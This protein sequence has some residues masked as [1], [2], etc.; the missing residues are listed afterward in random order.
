[1]TRLIRRW[2]ASA[3]LSVSIVAAAVS[4]S[5]GLD[6]VVRIGFQK[7]GKLVLLKGKGSLEQKLAPLGYK[8]V[9][10]EFPSGPPLLEAL[11]VGA[12]D[13]GNTGEA[14]PIFAQA[15]GAPIQY[16][17]YEPPAPK[18]EA[19]L[20]QKDSK[21]NSIADLKGRKVALNKGSN[22]HYLLVKALE[23]A[24]VKY[25]EIEPVFLAPADARAAFER[26]S[27]DAWVIWDPFQA[28][29][30]AA[31]GARTL[32]DGT[33]IVSNYQ[34]YFSSKKFL[35]SDPKIVDLVLAQL[36]EVDDW[37]KNDIHA[38]AE[39]IAPAVG[40]PVAVVEVA[41]KRQ[42]YGIKP[43]TDGVIAG[44]QQVADTF[45]ALGL[46]PKTIKISDVARRPGT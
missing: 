41:L 33:G 15:A 7:Y 20:V 23:K 38:V 1:M 18:G 46:L 19:V 10:T 8:V 4:A 21:L 14:P 17:A 32:A 16:V 30:E 39:Q 24:G 5:Y 43:I 27:V 36:S 13:F 9:W 6:K 45:F 31:T 2:I 26:G 44:Q 37:A 25:S 11:N 28:A 34:F 22:V 40:L 35:E 12:I 42:S 3:V 29:A